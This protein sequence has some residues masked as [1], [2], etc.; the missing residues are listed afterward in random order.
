MQV[1]RLSAS[2]EPASRGQPGLGSRTKD[3]PDTNTC[4]SSAKGPLPATRTCPE[5]NP[6]HVNS[7]RPSRV[8]SRLTEH[9]TR[10]AGYRAP[11]VQR[12]S[13]GL[14]VAAEGRGALGWGRGCS[15][16]WPGQG[17]WGWKGGPGGPGMRGP[18]VW[19]RGRPGW[20]TCWVAGCSRHFLELEAS[21]LSRSHVCAYE[22]CLGLGPRG[23]RR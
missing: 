2:R 23:R 17:M 10:G 1:T 15:P 3:P 7:V 19:E 13:V 22:P 5:P 4:G 20:E 8:R 6:E 21:L 18:E 14:T 11:A 12:G 9:L 16:A